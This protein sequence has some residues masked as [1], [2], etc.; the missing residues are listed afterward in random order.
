MAMQAA[1]ARWGYGADETSALLVRELGGRREIRAV[2]ASGG[3]VMR[4][5][6]AM[7]D[8]VEAW[9]LAP[10]AALIVEASADGGEA[11]RLALDAP[12]SRVRRSRAPLPDSAF[13]AGALRAAA[14]RLAWRCDEGVRMPASPGG[15]ELRCVASTRGWTG[16]NGVHGVGPLRLRFE[17]DSIGR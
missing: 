8:E 7:R 17:R 14:Q 9:Y 6:A 15:A 5:D 16:R 10:G 13:D 4:R 11:V 3:W 2:G 1:D 12:V